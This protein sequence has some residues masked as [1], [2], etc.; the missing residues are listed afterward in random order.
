MPNPFVQWEEQQQANIGFDA[1]LFHQ[2]I[3][4][5]VDAYQKNTDKMLV[6]MSVPVS[7]GYS[8]IYVPSINAGKMENKGIELT[9]NSKTLLEN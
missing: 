9:V 7:T 1:T 3:D 2:R 4:I 8:D 6:P 5:T